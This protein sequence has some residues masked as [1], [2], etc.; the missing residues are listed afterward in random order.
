MSMPA[1]SARSRRLP[2]FASHLLVAG[3]AADFA[4]LAVAGSGTVGLVLSAKYLLALAAAL[5]VPALR[6]GLRR[7]E[8]AVLEELDP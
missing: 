1:R 7:A 5:A 6:D 2:A 8:Q 4:L 3:L